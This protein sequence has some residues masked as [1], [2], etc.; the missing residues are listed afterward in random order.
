M[1][2]VP[3][4]IK[5][6]L[7]TDSVKKNIRIH[8]PNGERS[9]ICNDLIVMDSVSFKES[10]CSQNTFKFGLCESPIFECEVVRV[11]NI[12]GATI[13]VYCEVFCPSTVS[14]AVWRADIQQYVYPIKYGAFRVQSCERQSD[15]IHR[16]IVCY[17]ILNSNEGII[18]P[19]TLN[20]ITEGTTAN[21]AYAPDLMKLAFANVPRNINLGFNTETLSVSATSRSQMVFGSIIKGQSEY[22]GQYSKFRLLIDVN[23]HE[24]TIGS[25]GLSEDDLIKISQ[26]IKLTKAFADAL[27]EAVNTLIDGYYQMYQQRLSKEDLLQWEYANEQYQGT[28]M[29]LSTIISALKY[30]CARS[31]KIIKKES[32][33]FYLNV[34]APTLLPLVYVDSFYAKG[35]EPGAKLLLFSGTSARVQ[36]VEPPAPGVIAPSYSWYDKTVTFKETDQAISLTK[37]IPPFEMAASFDREVR[38]IPWGGATL[39]TRYVPKL[40]N[41][42]VYKVLDA[43]LELIGCFMNAPRD[44]QAAVIN[45]KDKFGLNASD[46]L[47]PGESV[48][49]LGV[50]GGS[51]VPQ[52][53]QTCWYD[54]HYT[55]PFGAILIAYKA[56]GNV[57]TQTKIYIG[58]YN[59]T[60][61]ESTYQIYQLTN[62]MILQNRV[63]D[64]SEL[65]TIAELIGNNIDG[66]TYM[67]VKLLGRGLPYVEPGDT[68]EVLTTS[69]DS[70]TT[71]VLSR[72]LKGEMFLTDEYVSVT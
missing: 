49:P 61:D 1:I 55:L 38:T 30:G 68:F 50:T 17:S 14:G 47:Y 31:S 48:K 11:S 32:G 5:D 24:Y 63:S 18:N 4:E 52:D 28:V 69:G 67:P 15:M 58:N 60:S 33:G 72:T 35:I 64:D 2:N 12:K 57:D 42:D 59:D 9:D 71:I 20:I 70:I 21:N 41:F 3:Q 44:G 40:D 23:V 53:Y 27:Y 39:T 34:E 8:F 7:H 43:A 6:L 56:S 13:E 19:V 46:T 10:L 51:I 36:L 54:E 65:T 16:K 25:G 37:I 66:V 62:N 22:S 45:I 26:S 29:T